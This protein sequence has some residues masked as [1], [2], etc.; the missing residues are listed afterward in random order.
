MTGTQTDRD[1]LDDFVDSRPGWKSAG[2]GDYRT[3][4]RYLN[5]SGHG[6]MMRLWQAANGKWNAELLADHMGEA[7]H[8][9]RNATFEDCALWLRDRE[10]LLDT[11]DTARATTDLPKATSIVEGLTNQQVETLADVY[12]IRSGGTEQKKQRLLALSRATRVPPSMLREFV[13]GRP[14]W[15]IEEA[16]PGHFRA[17][18]TIQVYDV[19]FYYLSFGPESPTTQSWCWTGDWRSSGGRVGAAVS[20]TYGGVI[21]QVVQV[22]KLLNLVNRLRECRTRPAALELV[23]PLKVRDLQ[24]LRVVLDLP[25]GSTDLIRRKLVQQTCGIRL[26]AS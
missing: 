3:A 16:E 9:L 17:H 21:P 10:D 15:R 5:L 22:E 14:G 24:F 4:H 13:E 20:G 23:H 19:A 7:T 1:L 6:A 2:V 12:G 11:F 18:R 26:D 25:V 8:D